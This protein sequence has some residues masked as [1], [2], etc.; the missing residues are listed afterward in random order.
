MAR[1]DRP[2][3]D[4]S[5]LLAGTIDF[6]REAQPAQRIMTAVAEARLTRPRTAWHCCLEFYAVATRLPEELRLSPSDARRLLEG[7]ILSRFDVHALPKHRWKSF[8]ESLER[9]GILGGR[10]YDA[11]IAEIARAT[12]A[13]VVVTENT[14]HFLQLGRH[15]VAVMTCAEFVAQAAV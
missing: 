7:E 2:F 12:G 10:I 3:F 15:G 14:R 6:G 4:T 5:V 8:A 1:V 13:R 11:H 9:D